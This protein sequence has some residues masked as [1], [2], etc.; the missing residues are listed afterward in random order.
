[1][2]QHEPEAAQQPLRHMSPQC[3]DFCQELSPA[4]EKKGSR[5]V[6]QKWT[7]TPILLYS[8]A[9]ALYLLSSAERVVSHPTILTL[10]IPSRVFPLTG[11]TAWTSHVGREMYIV[12]LHD[13]FWMG[14]VIDHSLVNPKQLPHHGVSSVQDNNPFDHT[15]M[16]LAAED[17]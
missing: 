2:L 5:T 9:I 10:M 15:A 8:D 7:H 16:H 3:A 11:A 1:M 12:M 13:T 17:G 4:C 6:R 14:E